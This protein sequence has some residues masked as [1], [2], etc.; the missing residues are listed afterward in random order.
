LQGLY[1]DLGFISFNIFLYRNH[2]LAGINAVSFL[3][4]FKPIGFHFSE[5]ISLKI[6]ELNLNSPTNRYFAEFHDK[7]FGSNQFLLS[8][9][10]CA[11]STY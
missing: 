4:F 11:L 3:N 1:L 2:Q 5:L 7:I 8:I 9:P 6:D 10:K